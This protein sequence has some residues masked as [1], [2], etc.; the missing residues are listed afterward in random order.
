[1]GNPVLHEL[2]G[3]SGCLSQEEIQQYLIAGL[4]PDQ[5]HRIENHLL[6]C[7]LCSDAVEGYQV[8]APAQSFPEDYTSWRK[9][10]PGSGEMGQVRRLPV[11][12]W[13][14]GVAAAA[15]IILVAYLGF[16]RTSSAEALFQKYYVAY[17]LDI[18]V[19]LRNT[20]IASSLDALLLEALQEYDSG[21]YMSSIKAFDS[22]LSA[23]PDN[24]IAL[25]FSA[26]A[27]LQTGEVDR[28][29]TQLLTL[30]KI[31]SNYSDKARWYLALVQIKSHRED[32][33][34]EL[35]QQIVRDKSFKHQRAGELLKQME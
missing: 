35:L 9:K 19:S 1:M 17:P 32:E 6:D 8:I 7:P 22:V 12:K 20:T 30:L 2:F 27:S 31:N 26:M 24:G 34:V 28:A 16:F 33:A 23:D 25:F 14:W 5:C 15:A 3:A 10:L 11:G 18:P 21:H 4:D 13:W 29:K